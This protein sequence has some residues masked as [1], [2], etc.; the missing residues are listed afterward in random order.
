MVPATIGSIIAIVT[1]IGLAKELWDRRYGT[2]F[3]WYDM[4]ANAL[5]MATGL[6]LLIPFTL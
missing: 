5:G 3:C 4:L 1:A 2:G 6:I